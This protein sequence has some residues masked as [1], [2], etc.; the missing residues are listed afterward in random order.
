MVRHLGVALVLTVSAGLAL[1]DSP[2][3]LLDTYKA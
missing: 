3:N 2:A 1:A